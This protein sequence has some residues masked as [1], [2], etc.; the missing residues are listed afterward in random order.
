VSVQSN[1][2]AC[3]G[4]VEFKVDSSVVTICPYCRSAVAR[5]DKKLED[6][7][8]V[9]DLVTTGSLLEVGRRGRYQGV[10][11]DLTGRAQ[12]AHQSGGVWDEWYAHFADG[13]WGWLAEAQGRFYLT[14]Q[15]PPGDDPPEFEHVQLGSRHDLGGTRLTVAEKGEARTV[16]A[17]GEI[18]YLLEPDRLHRYA[19]LSGSD[20]EFGTLDFGESPP[21]AF[22]GREATADDLG[23]PPNLKPVQR[24]GARVESLHLNCPNCGGPLELR[25]P[26]KTE[27]VG[28]PNCAAL[29]DC[30][31]GHLSL[32]K[33][34]DV[35]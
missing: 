29:L 12:Y 16:S 26:D 2:P 28:C 7:G 20:G 25:A 19:D 13:R 23:F 31:A 3:G 35:C 9:A 11:F 6:L 24:D 21:L 14:F 27:R 8:K 33:A 15:V 4:P 1:C 5:G 22:V 34:L 30:N 32:L 18:P 17:E 10:P